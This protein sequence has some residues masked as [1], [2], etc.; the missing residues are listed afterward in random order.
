MKATRTRWVRIPESEEL[1]WVEWPLCWL[2]AFTDSELELRISP[3]PCRGSLLREK[4]AQQSFW[5]SCGTG[6]ADWEIEK[7]DQ[8]P[9]HIASWVPRKTDT[10][11]EICICRFTDE[12]FLQ[13]LCGSKRTR[14]WK[15]LIGDTHSGDSGLNQ[16]CT[17]LW[18]WDGRLEMSPI[19]VRGLGLWTWINQSLD[20]DC[21]WGWGNNLGWSILFQSSAV[22]REGCTYKLSADTPG[23]CENECSRPEEGSGWR[24]YNIHYSKWHLLISGTMWEA[25]ESEWRLLKDRWKSSLIS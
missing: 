21:P 2:A 16:S 1:S 19:E 5:W 20:A 4:E 10:E 11:S 15:K 8:F 6:A 17:E 13:H 24:N 7:L 22:P 23:S 18:S 12:S 3:G 14:I 9:P 25:T